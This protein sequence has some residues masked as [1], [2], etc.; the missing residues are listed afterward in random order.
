MDWKLG[1]LTGLV[2]FGGLGL[3]LI[4][5]GVRP[6]VWNMSR[7]LYHGVRYPSGLSNAADTLQQE[8]LLINAVYEREEVKRVERRLRVVKA[9]G[10]E[11]IAFRPRYD[12][13]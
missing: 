9:T 12:D 3:T 7:L 13:E 8:R 10:T 1:I 4:L 6:V 2:V 5:W 11:P